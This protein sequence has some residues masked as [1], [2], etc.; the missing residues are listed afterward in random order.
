MYSPDLSSKNLYN[1]WHNHNPKELDN[2]D[3]KHL[4]NLFAPPLSS[5][6]SNYPGVD[7]LHLDYNNNSTQ[8]SQIFTTSPL[9]QS[10][11][12]QLEQIKNYGYSTIRPIG[13][14]KTMEEIDYLNQQ[15]IDDQTQL[16]QI[17]HIAAENSTEGII[18]NVN[19]TT[20]SI[21][22]QLPQE[23]LDAQVLNADENSNS[24]SEDDESNSNTDHNYRIQEDDFMAADVEYQDDHSLNS[25][26]AANIMNSG[27]TAIL[28]NTGRST[29]PTTASVTGRSS[30][31]VAV[32]Q[33]ENEYLQEEMIIE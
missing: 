23:D 5:Y 19:G 6:S 24:N 8:N 31:N 1:L 9:V 21:D 30:I 12:I 32:E 16:S 4:K 7:I 29:N 26:T 15:N 22:N 33:N 2:V 28:N 27:S 3:K 14:G 25:E 11:F 13:I 20:I 18:N 17:T 10:N